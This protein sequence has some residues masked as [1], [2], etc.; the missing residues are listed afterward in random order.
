MFTVLWVHFAV[1]IQLK[2]V[3]KSEGSAAQCTPV[4]SLPVVK[5]TR[6]QLP[7][8]PEVDSSVH[9]VSTMWG[10]YT[11]DCPS[12]YYHIFTHLKSQIKVP[13]V[14]PLNFMHFIHQ[15]FSLCWQILMLAKRGGLKWDLF[16][17][18]CNFL[19]WCQHSFILSEHCI[20][21][22]RI[23]KYWGMI[24]GSELLPYDQSAV[25]W[26]C[27]Y[28]NTKQQFW[29]ALNSFSAKCLSV[30]HAEQFS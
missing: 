25:F 5:T 15:S 21:R 30:L 8:K 9:T 26:M 10:S 14:D 4:T 27:T 11:D 6:F 20:G 7:H 18:P 23:V 28:V 29:L 13:S 24:L 22:Q 1:F 17:Y 16:H 2:G 3:L 19:P 12:Q